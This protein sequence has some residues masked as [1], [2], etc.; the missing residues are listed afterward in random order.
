[1]RT[2]QWIGMAAL[3]VAAPAQAQPVTGGNDREELARAELIAQ[4]E[5]ASD[6]GDHTRALDLAT[7]ALAVRATPSLRLLL[8]TEHNALGHV[9]DAYELSTRCAREAQ[10]DPATRNRAQVIDACTTL[11]RTLDARIGRVTLRVTAP[12]AGMRVRVAGGEVSPALWGVPYTVS[13]GNVLIEASA[14]GREPF[15]R[16]VTVTAG[17]V[18]PVEVELRATARASA[19]AAPRSTPTPGAPTRRPDARD[20]APERSLAGPIALAVGSAVSFTLAGVFFGLREGTVEERDGQCSAAGCQ[21]TSLDLDD[22]ARTQN[23]MVNVFLGV[24]GAALAGAV[25]WYFV[26]RPS[27]RA[28]THATVTGTLA[29]VQGGAIFGVGGTL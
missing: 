21:P 19:E 17:Q 8:A 24:G 25:V 23:T 10:A 6:Q 12:P 26:G 28:S 5:A 18:V 15:R 2:T 29:P 3:A 7:R 27:A 11:S 13:P 4:A 20:V 14:E 1:M 16:E 9:I 22:T